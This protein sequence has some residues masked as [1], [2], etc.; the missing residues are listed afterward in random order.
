V[1]GGNCT[2]PGRGGRGLIAAVPAL[3]QR[4]VRFAPTGP[5]ARPGAGRAGIARRPGR[6]AWVSGRGSRGARRGANRRM[7][8]ARRAAPGLSQPGG[9]AAAEAAEAGIGTANRLTCPRDP[10][11][12]R[13][14]RLD[15]GCAED[16]LGDAPAPRIRAGRS[17]GGAAEGARLRSPS[18]AAAGRRSSLVLSSLCHGTPCET[19][20]RGGPLPW[21][22]R[23]ARSRRRPRSR[24]PIAGRGHVEVATRGPVPV[25]EMGWPC[26]TGE[27]CPHHVQLLQGIT[28][29]ALAPFERR[30]RP[31]DREENVS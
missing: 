15:G 12:S 30:E 26:S 27:S 25:P 20:C 16:P 21:D 8:P 17:T 18:I 11:R 6:G 29:R 13:T 2:H 9:E 22:E 7:R 4:V 31:S 10:A 24:P 28:F 3:R 19:S 23:G 14:V 5:V 1:A